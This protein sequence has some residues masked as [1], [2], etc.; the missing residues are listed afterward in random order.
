MLV[1]DVYVRS[2]MSFDFCVPSD[3]QPLPACHTM[4]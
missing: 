2:D 4:V 1:L 3:P